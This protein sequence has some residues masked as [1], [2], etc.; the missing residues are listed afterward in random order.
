VYYVAEGSATLVDLGSDERA[1]LVT[2]T[3][4]HIEPQT[5]Y[6]FEAGD[7][8]AL[9]LSGPCPPDPALYGEER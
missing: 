1:E 6:R 4:A 3:M 5:S 7:D 9:L 8:G 2:G